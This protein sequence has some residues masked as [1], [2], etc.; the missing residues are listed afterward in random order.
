MRSLQNQYNLIKE[1][2]SS[3]DVFLKSAKS[4][5]PN[6]IPSHYG[7][8][9]T[10][11]ILKEKSI[12]SE[13]L[14]GVVTKGNQN[15]DWFKIFN[16]NI[17]EAKAE[18]KKPTK[19]VVDTETRAFDYKDPKNI[20]NIYGPSFLKGFYTE[21]C[22]PKNEG[23]TVDELK[24]IVAKNLNKNLTYYTEN[25]QFGLDGIGYTTE[26]P[27]LG[28][29]KEAK[30]KYKSSGY[31]DLK[32]SLNTKN[33]QFKKGDKVTYLGYPGEITGINTE[34][35]GDISY[36]V[37]YDKGTGK[38][39]VTNIYNKDGEIK[40][41]KESY[42]SSD[43]FKGT[44][45]I[46]VGSTQIDN[47]RIQDVVDETDYYGVWNAVEG[48]WF[49]PE[50]E[51]IL[52]QLEIILTREFDIRDISARFEGQFNESLNEGEYAERAEK[53]KKKIIKKINDLIKAGE[54]REEAI[55]KT[56]EDGRNPYFP[57]NDDDYHNFLNSIESSIIGEEL[58]EG[59]GMSLED[60]KDEAQSISRQE[61]IVQHV[62]ETEP[63]SGKYR[64][65][66]WYDSDLTVISYERGLPKNENITKLK[67]L[68]EAEY[69]E[70][71]KSKEKKEVKKPAT[72]KAKTS[73]K[74][75]AIETQGSIAALEAKIE[76]L[77]EEISN[78][79]TKMKMATENEDFAEF[80]NEKKVKMMEKEVKQLQK[81]QER[82]IKEYKKYTGEDYQAKKEIVDETEE[83]EY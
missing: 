19:E 42:G 83:M 18:E 77:E 52:D 55:A 72:K 60:A 2:K 75:K 56:L 30:G 22:N 24:E 54:S 7:F 79:E 39:K 66:D 13:S 10:V 33:T 82:Y 26:H 37:R 20:D 76:A 14:G 67:D 68:L 61:G 69:Y 50:D 81:A 41:L 71:F 49:F 40:H 8:N 3:K 23:K 4:L 46:V 51:E 17:T 1:G 15:P 11:N 59:Y 28:T 32:E 34:M 80:V 74:I 31:G 63:G 58:N 9:E 64:V 57:H 44:G 12:I 27:G 47:N 36:N 38:T 43:D 5:F 65:S 35:G 73:D 45:L 70:T 16:E 62:E 25:G 53:D 21:M 78:R 6:Y 29:P 48:Y